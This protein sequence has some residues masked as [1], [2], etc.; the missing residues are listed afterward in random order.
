V[1]DWDAANLRE[2]EED[3][4]ARLPLGAHPW[5]VGKTVGRT[6]YDAGDRLIGVMDTRELATIVVAS[7]ALQEP[8][9]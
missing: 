2:Q 3:R 9:S 6:I 7:V 1:S 8:P 5:R 4:K